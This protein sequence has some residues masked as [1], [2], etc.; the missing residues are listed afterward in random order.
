VRPS[1]F[2][3]TEALGTVTGREGHGV[4]RGYESPAGDTANHIRAYGRGHLLA[5]LIYVSYRS[6]QMVAQAGDRFQHVYYESE[7]KKDE[8]ESE[9]ETQSSP[10]HFEILGSSGPWL[11]V[12]FG[13]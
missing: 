13:F 10:P 6:A 3:R 7:S 9:D 2:A 8:N 11:S 4:A 1:A 12:V 5:D